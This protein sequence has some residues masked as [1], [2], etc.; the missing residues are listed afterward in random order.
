MLQFSLVLVEQPDAKPS[1]GTVPLIEFLPGHPARWS[2]DTCHFCAM[3]DELAVIKPDTPW[4]PDID[5]AIVCHFYDRNLPIQTRRAW[6][7]VSIMLRER[8]DVTRVRTQ[9]PRVP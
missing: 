2:P 4:S 8:L 7:T 5:R 9:P 6:A 3:Y 1:G